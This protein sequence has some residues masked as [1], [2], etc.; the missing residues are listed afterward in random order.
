MIQSNNVYST[1]YDGIQR[2][3]LHAA[4]NGN[5]RLVLSQ[6]IIDELIRFS[7]RSSG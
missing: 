7:R 5:I 1:F 3:V 6:E 4:I 2:A